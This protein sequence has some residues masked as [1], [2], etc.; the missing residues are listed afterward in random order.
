MAQEIMRI[1]SGAAAGTGLEVET[2]L[3]IG[4]AAEGKGTLDGDQELSRHHARITRANGVLTIEDLGSTN[5]TY[6]NGERISGPRQLRQGDSISVGGTTIGV[7]AAQS[8]P[9]DAATQRTTVRPRMQ[10][11]TLSSGP[12]VEA[13][14]PSSEAGVRSAS[15]AFP[16]FARAAGGPEQSSGVVQE[17][18][19]S[20]LGA[21]IGHNLKLLLGD[22]GPIILYLVIPVLS[23]LVMRP[24]MKTILVQEGYKNVNG[25]EQAVPGFMIM[26]LFLW[27]ITLGRG[28]FV[29][30]GWNTW[31]RMR[32]SQASVG[33]V[34]AGKLLPGALL[35]LA[36]I[37]ITMVI[38]LT[39][40]GMNSRGP[41]PVLLVVAVPLITCVLAMTAA[42][43]AL[44]QT[45]AQLEAIG[46][47]ILIVF[48]AMGG[49]LTPV[50]S[51]PPTIRA[52]GHAFPSYWALLA[53]HNVILDGKGIS[54]V[55]VPAGVL[56][57][58]TLVFLVIAMLRFN[59]SQAKRIEI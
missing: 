56:A 30:H 51:L 17:R 32:A 42:I 54:G 58:M 28:F 3:V 47:M 12:P 4:R 16:K 57:G 7:L 9:A 8:E 14:P 13:A 24:T 35:I 22:P 40:F 5:G 50:A 27:V 33:Q 36:Q 10:T 15:Y 38:G 6:V 25:S 43:V 53:A 39:V 20:P 59:S 55:L 29:E 34:L 37:V 49:A 11:T 31:E 48:A 1:T 18:M 41:L 21:L 45:Y 2:E 46:N 19:A 26:F 44:V 23:I 52:I